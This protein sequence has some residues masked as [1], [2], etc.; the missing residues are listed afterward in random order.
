MAGKP[1]IP[2]VEWGGIC[3]SYKAGFDVSGIAKTHNVAREAIYRI[4]RKRGVPVEKRGG[5]P[6]IGESICALICDMYTAKRGATSIARQFGIDKRSVYNILIKAG[7]GTR[8]RN[9]RTGDAYGIPKY[10]AEQLSRERRGH[11]RGPRG[12]FNFDA[13]KDLD[14][15][16]CYWAGYLITD[17]CIGAYDG[18]SYRLYLPQARKH[19]EQCEKLKEYLHSELDVTD[20]QA[21]TFGKLRDFSSVSFTLPDEVAQRLLNLGIRPAKTAIA[22]APYCLLDKAPFWRG[23]VEGD[24]TVR[25]DYIRMNSASPRLANAYR[26]VIRGLFGSRA[27]TVVRNQSGVWGINT[28]RRDVLYKLASWLYPDDSALGLGRKKIVGRGLARCKKKTA[29]E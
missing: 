16:T 21:V 20:H 5:S 15:N 8:P 25:N 1:R 9:N 27:G 10:Q 18:R 13:F 7:I 6:P 14:E 29:G 17:G 11:K 26:R 2:E 12:N 23:V 24:G 4:L 19:R 28:S 3:C 22:Q